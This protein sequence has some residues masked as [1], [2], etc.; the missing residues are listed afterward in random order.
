MNDLISILWTSDQ[1]NIHPRTPT[2][3]I[4]NN[5]SDFYYKQ[6]DLSKIALAIF[7]GD[8]THRSV[9]A[10][11]KE[12]L[13][14]NGWMS[15]FSIKAAETKTIV[16]IIEGTSSHDYEQPAHFVHSADKDCDF[17]Y[18]DKL[19]VEVFDKLGGLTVMY[20]P[21]NMGKL[22]TDTIWE[23]ALAELARLN[24]K[25]VDLIAFHGAFQYQLPPQA[26]KHTHIES[27]WESIAKYIILAG[28][29]HKPSKRGKI[30]CSGSFDRTAH[31]EEHPKG[32]Y[33][34]EIDL[35]H[36]TC[37]A[38]FRENKNALP[39]LTYTVDQSKTVDDLIKDIH[40]FITKNKMPAFSR[41]KLRGGRSDVI[42]PVVNMLESEYSYLGFDVDNE[43]DESIVLEDDLFIADKYEGVTLNRD[44]LFDNLW[45]SMDSTVDEEDGL[46]FDKE[47][48][49]A[50]FEE[51]K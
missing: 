27:R 41:L 25:Q 20:V 45:A 8:M 49:R 19:S 46:I 5:M 12:W 21:D 43:K 28:H 4:L 39:F 9:D 11:N 23:M 7:G 48:Y 36:E 50:L 37:I 26:Q 15:K 10:H 38:E 18:I 16:R 32:G 42:T 14:V 33:Y 47:E 3:H 31:A 2:N 1:H 51:F 13:A 6:H 22:S 29:I 34:V 44:N 24:L 30:H 35:K 40:L 17:K